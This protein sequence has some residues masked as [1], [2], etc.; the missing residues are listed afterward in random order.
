M[1]YISPGF[2]DHYQDLGKLQVILCIKHSFIR[3]LCGNQPRCKPGRSDHD[4]DAR[5]TCEQCPAYKHSDAGVTRCLPCEAGK[6][7]N[8]NNTAC[9]PCPSGTHS[10]GL[11]AECAQCPAG[12]EP[13]RLQQV[14]I[15][16]YYY[17]P[18]LTLYS[19]VRI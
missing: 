7:A 19:Q 18:M 8:N 13:D 17:T 4:D 10:R 5:T 1:P 16:L 6:Q 2:S 9:Q 15:M 11:A 12:R 14:S 3:V